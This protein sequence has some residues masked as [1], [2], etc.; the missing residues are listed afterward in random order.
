LF[1][2]SGGSNISLM[3]R[4]RAFYHLGSQQEAADLI[5]FGREYAA[6][7]TQ[8]Q[9]DVTF[10][11]LKISDVALNLNLADPSGQGRRYRY[12]VAVE[13]GLEFKTVWLNTDELLN[14]DQI[15]ANA[16][17]TMNF[18]GKIY[19]HIAEFLHGTGQGEVIVHL[20][21]VERRY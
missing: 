9:L 2:K 5:R 18:W 8:L 21:S 4:V 13:V 12:Q 3:N 17:S 10:G 20:Q 14:I 16:T 6:S 7:L 19:P 11:E 15:R 1:F